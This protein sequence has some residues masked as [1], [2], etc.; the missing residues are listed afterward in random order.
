MRW[1]G[2]KFERVSG[3]LFGSLGDVDVAPVRRRLRRGAVHDRRR[4]AVE[5]RG[6]HEQP[7]RNGAIHLE[8][9][10]PRVALVGVGQEDDVAEIRRR[11]LRDVDRRARPAAC[12]SAPGS[13]SG[14]DVLDVLRIAGIPRCRPGPRKPARGRSRGCRGSARVLV[15][16]IDHVDLVGRRVAHRSCGWLL[17]IG[18][19]RDAVVGVEPMRDA[20]TRCRCCRTG[21]TARRRACGRRTARCRRGSAPRRCRRKRLVEAD[22]RRPRS[23]DGTTSVRRPKSPPAAG[24]AVGLSGNVGTSTRRP[25][26]ERE[27]R[28]RTPLVAGVEA[29]LPHAEP[30]PPARIAGQREAVVERLRQALLEAGRGWRT[31]SCRS[32]RG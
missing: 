1:P 8:R 19:E 12:R 26:G 21:S 9:D 30:A 3:G 28:R 24:C 10:A 20:G 27:V 2:S 23:A 32:C 29:E 16:G 11:R 17:R 5:V 25:Y 13:G 14:T 7:L 15:V 18:D 22:A 31:G 4:L 6:A